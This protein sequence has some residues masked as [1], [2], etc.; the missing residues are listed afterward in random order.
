VP[1]FVNR[2]G[3][4]MVGLESLE[5]A[6]SVHVRDFFFPEDQSRLMDEFFPQVLESGHGEI[7]IRFRHFKTGQALWMAYKVLK[8]ADETG[9]FGWLTTSLI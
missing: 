1:I 7:D 9:W 8:L 4:Q 2:S 5:Q 6:R 3:L